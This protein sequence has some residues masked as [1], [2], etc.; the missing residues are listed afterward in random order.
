[1]AAKILQVYTKCTSRTEKEGKL[2]KS[3]ETYDSPKLLGLQRDRDTGASVL[4]ATG[5]HLSS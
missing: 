5:R 4:I 2:A 1:M 3:V